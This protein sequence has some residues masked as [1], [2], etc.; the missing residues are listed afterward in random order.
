MYFILYF[1]YKSIGYV[2]RGIKTISR[3]Q[4]YTAQG[5]RAPVLKFLD[6]PLH[7]QFI[8]STKLLQRA[9][10]RHPISRHRHQLDLVISRRSSLNCVLITRSN[11]SADCDTYHSSASLA[12]SWIHCSRPKGHPHTHTVRTKLPGQRKRFANTVDENLHNC[13]TNSVEER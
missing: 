7:N 8:F 3:P 11:H 9:S 1:Q 2:W 13:P 4:N 10:W 12:K 5:P 6:P